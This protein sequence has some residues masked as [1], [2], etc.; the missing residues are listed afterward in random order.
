MSDCTLLCF[1]R[2]VYTLVA[3]PHCLWP[4]IAVCEF[5]VSFSN[6]DLCSVFLFCLTSNCNQSFFHLNPLLSM[7]FQINTVPS[8][9]VLLCDD[10]I[11]GCIIFPILE[12]QELCTFKSVSLFNIDPTFIY[13]THS[14][15]SCFILFFFQFMFCVCY[16]QLLYYWLS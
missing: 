16:S 6:F 5:W 1:P 8:H 4:Y 9:S 10:N 13:Q 11:V 15:L 2:K 3:L 7:V 12:T 14:A